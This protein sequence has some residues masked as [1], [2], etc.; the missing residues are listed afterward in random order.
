MMGR[1]ACLKG[2]LALACVVALALVPAAAS[3]APKL[4]LGHAGRWITD[5]KGRAVVIHGINMVYKLPPYYPSAVGFGADD[6]AFLK[7]IGFNAVRVGVLWQAVEPKPG[8]YDDGYLRQIASTVATLAR[9][10]IVSLLDF[11]QDQY[12]QLFQGEGFPGWSVQDDGLPPSRSSASAPTTSGCRHSSGPS[13]TSGRTPRGPVAWG[14]RTATR[15]RGSTWPSISRA[16]RASSGTR[17]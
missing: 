7:S 1:S 5:A 17:S 6:A 13:T 4:P 2:S 3:A 10:G 15:R 8:V 11:H 9:F 12:N 16:I 14:S